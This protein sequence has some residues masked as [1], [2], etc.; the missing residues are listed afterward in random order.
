V[1]VPGYSGDASPRSV[2][3]FEFTAPT[4]APKQIYVILQLKGKGRVYFD[5]VRIAAHD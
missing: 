3:T 5:D 2:P 1:A 4:T